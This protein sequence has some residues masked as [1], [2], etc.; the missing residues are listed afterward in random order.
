VTGGLLYLDPLP[1]TAK[2]A[3][4]VSHPYQGKS[5]CLLFRAQ[6]FLKKVENLTIN[7]A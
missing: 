1:L 6:Y 4:N 5:H 7:I 3:T 2:T